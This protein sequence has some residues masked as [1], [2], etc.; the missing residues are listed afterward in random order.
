VIENGVIL[1]L[2]SFITVS[3]CFPFTGLVVDVD[4]VDTRPLT[5]GGRG[6]G[7]LCPGVFPL[8]AGIAMCAAITSFCLTIPDFCCRLSN[9]GSSISCFDSLL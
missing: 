3:F 6:A 9:D 8:L 5:E 4:D 2:P 1:L 7:I